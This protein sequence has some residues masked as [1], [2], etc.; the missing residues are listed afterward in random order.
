MLQEWKEP[1]ARKSIL[2]T[3]VRNMQGRTT[4]QRKELRDASEFQAEEH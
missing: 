1:N 2:E 3:L 4:E